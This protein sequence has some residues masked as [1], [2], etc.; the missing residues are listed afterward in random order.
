MLNIYFPFGIST[1]PMDYTK[2]LG[3]KF[4]R[5]Q[6]NIDDMDAIASFC[7]IFCVMTVGVF[8]H[9]YRDKNNVLLSQVRDTPADKASS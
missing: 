9:E 7:V 4:S 1:L 6:V 2:E 3:V 8:L 5:T